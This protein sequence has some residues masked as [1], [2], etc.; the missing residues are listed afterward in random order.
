[1]SSLSGV[2]WLS[3][4]AGTGCHSDGETRDVP[5]RPG[6]CCVGPEHSPRP[7][8]PLGSGRLCG[9]QPSLHLLVIDAVPKRGPPPAPSPRHNLCSGAATFAVSRECLCSG[10]DGRRPRRRPEV[11]GHRRLPRCGPGVEPL[12]PRW[13]QNPRCPKSIYTWPRWDSPRPAAPSLCSE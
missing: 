11:P 13:E 12:P 9:A 4:P 2:C 5:R 7:G 10:V 6:R 1:M 3:A 8:N